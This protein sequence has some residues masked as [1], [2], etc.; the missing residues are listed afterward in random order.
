[1][2]EGMVALLHTHHH[3]WQAKGRSLTYDAVAK[4][5]HRK[6]GAL[7]WAIQQEIVMQAG[8]WS[9]TVDLCR[10]QKETFFILGLL[11]VW[12]RALAAWDTENHF[13]AIAATGDIKQ[14]LATLDRLDANDR[15]EGK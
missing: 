12:D 8:Q 15:R 7:S 6:A 11:C 4:S 2:K 5:V 13:R 10:L 1:M 9:R 14:A 3:R